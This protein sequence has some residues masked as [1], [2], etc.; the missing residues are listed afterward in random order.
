MMK[1]D[2][3]KMIILRPIRQEDLETRVEWMNN[4][5]VYS[6][7]HFEIPVTLDNTLKWFD[8]N[9]GMTNRHDVAF[10]RIG[11]SFN[12]EEELIAFG[13]LTSI[14]PV[15][16]KA[17]LYI[18]VSPFL[19]HQGL[20]LQATKLLCEYGF[21]ELG[22]NKIYLET[23]EDNFAAQRV[24]ERCGFVLEGRLREEYLDEN[25]YAKDRLYYGLLMRDWQKQ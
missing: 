20:G 22:L 12:I 23:N 11:E 24:Y 3:R 10:E 4:P 19:Q 17:E 2:L 16:R 21:S 13:G 8:R 14:D 15:L 18:F 25:G 9:K 1:G 6:S 7:M 5:R